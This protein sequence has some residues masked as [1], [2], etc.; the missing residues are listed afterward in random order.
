MAE[1]DSLR[2][3]LL[4]KRT[5]QC[6]SSSL[7][8]EAQARTEEAP[9][10]PREILALHMRFFRAVDRGRWLTARRLAALSSD[11]RP[12]TDITSRGGTV[13]TA[14]RTAKASTL[15]L[16]KQVMMSDL[17]ELHAA[18]ADMPEAT[19]KARRQQIGTRLRRLKLGTTTTLQ[20]VLARDGTW[21]TQPADIMKALQQHWAEVFTG[22]A[23][24][25]EAISSWL[26][27]AYPQGEG[28]QHF[29]AVPTDSWHIRRRD[30]AKA[31]SC[32]G[33]SAPGPDG[34]PYA[35]WKATGSYG[36][37]LLWQSARQLGT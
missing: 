5:M 12:F 31:L 17:R 33:R 14:P 22:A 15:D 37:D 24:P 2:S 23:M 29:P 8:L 13:E 1:V 16:A 10:V 11:L 3:L 34:L 19:A 7:L 32:A 30:V 6:V 4:F 20:T 36:I 18:T 27:K 26:H 28:L 21:A 25:K 35:A 9:K